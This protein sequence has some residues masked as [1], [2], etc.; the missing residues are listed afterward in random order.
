MTD[1]KL[2]HYVKKDPKHKQ[3]LVEASKKCFEHYT[4]QSMSS[5][6]TEDD[7]LGADH[8]QVAFKLPA[9]FLLDAVVHV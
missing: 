8:Q 4:A 7:M 6:L 1:R 5:D 3:V 9:D 2:S